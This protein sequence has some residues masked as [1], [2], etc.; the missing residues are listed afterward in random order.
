ML[1]KVG[2]FPRL[3]FGIIFGIIIGIISKSTGFVFPVRILTTFSAIFGNFLNFIIPF[4][5]I[6]FIVP[7]ISKLGSGSGKLLGITVIIAYVSTIFAG[8][9]AFMAGNWILPH[10]LKIGQLAPKSNLYLEPFFK[11]EIPP[12]MG[13][14]TALVTAFMI[15]LGIAHIKGKAL[16]NV[17]YDFE[18]ILEL[19]IKNIL[20]P[21]IPIHISGIFS[22]LTANGEIIST[23]KAF[24]IV[25]IMLL[26]IQG[27]YLAIQ[28]SIAWS[29]SGRSPLKSLK[30]MLPAY[31]TA[32]GTQSSAASIPFTLKCTKK[33]GVSEDIANFVIPLCATIHLAGDTITITLSAMAVLMMSGTIPTFAMMMPFI[34]MLGVTMVAAPGIPGGGIYAS[35]GLLKDMLLFT[36]PQQGI[37]IALHVSQDS[38]GTATNITGDC[39]LSMIIDKISNKYRNKSLNKNN[40]LYTDNEVMGA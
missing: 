27:I 24:S 3:I 9:L 17:F 12:A 25:Y 39:A 22:K 32:V 19:V 21:L 37:M 28:Y 1:K 26:L 15:G 29:V 40:N 2:L 20:V 13:V 5:I 36:Q 34:L 8:L 6:G 33:N 18:N 30:N 38:F 11:I 7:G 23:I 35:L 14:M 31:F 4:I 10:V 16:M